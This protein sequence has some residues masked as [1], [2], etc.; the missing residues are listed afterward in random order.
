M[1]LGSMSETY[2]EMLDKEYI[3]SDFR[4]SVRIDESSAYLK[5]ST[6]TKKPNKFIDYVLNILKK[7]KNFKVNEEEFN[8]LKKAYWGSML[9]SLNDVEYIGISYPEY[10]F[11]SCDFFEAVEKLQDVTYEEIEDLKE[12]FDSNMISTIII[13]K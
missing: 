13:K 9:M 3:G 8:T 12:Y 4:Y 1:L 7:V 2:Q 5:I 6:D 10:Y 11:K